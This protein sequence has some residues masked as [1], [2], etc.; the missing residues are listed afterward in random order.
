MAERLLV[1]GGGTMGSGIALVGAMAGYDVEIVEPYAAERERGLAFLEREAKRLSVAS[2]LEHLRWS[3]AIPAS[4]DAPIAIEAV[5]ERFEVKRQVFAAL[6]DALSP[7]ALLATNTSS[8]SVADLAD[9]VPHPERVLGMH[10]F[11]PPTRME[12][13]EIVCAPQTSDDALARAYDVAAKIRKTPV[14]AAD[15]PG[16][17]VNRVARPYYLQALRALERGVASAAELD[18]LARAIGFRMGP[19][20]LMDLIGLDV[21]LATTE[22]IYARTQEERFAPVELQ[23]QM[24]GQGLL[25]RK[26]GVGFYDYRDG[27]AERFQPAAT[28][29]QNEVNAQERVAIV[30]FGGV[31]DELAERIA[32]AYAHVVRIENDDFLDELLSEPTIVIDVGDGVADRGEVVAEL[33]SSLAAQSIF[34]VDAYA[35]DLGAC[36]RRLRHPERVVGYG[37]LGSLEAQHAVEIVDSEAVADD[38]VELAQ[39]FFAALDKSFVLVDD[40]PG[41]F[42]GRT[43][44]SIVNEAIV[45]VADE[46]ASPDDIDTA[47]RLGANYPIGPIAWGRAIG[48]ARVRRILSRLADSEGEAFAP[49]RSLWMLD[50]AEAPSPEEAI[51]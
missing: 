29:G 23:R 8:L 47:M 38:A 48:G 35:T 37:L 32:A 6:A 17:I 40:T 46:V 13:L 21:N 44:G 7:N 18:A 3:N 1:V 34:F 10:F 39:E 2:A 45:A 42:L 12:L 33:D 26:S 49:H 22:S 28:A 51:E 5:S 50:V 14:L 20:E 9:A 31:A 43:I 27:K 25:G 41:L 4:C 24:V 36:A 30:G 11:N 19:F 15:T 16:F